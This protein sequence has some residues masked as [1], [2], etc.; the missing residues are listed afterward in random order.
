MRTDGSDPAPTEMHRRAAEGVTGPGQRL[1]HYPQIQRAFGRH[2]LS[3]VRA[4]VDG[5]A[6]VASRGINAQAYALGERVAF[7]RPPTLHTAAHEAAHVIQQRRGV[8]LPMGIGQA[9]DRY[10]RH[11]NQVADRVVAGQ[12]AADLLDPAPAASGRPASLQR[13]D[14]QY[15]YRENDTETVIK[16]PDAQGTLQERARAKECDGTAAIVPENPKKGTSPTPKAK[17]ISQAATRAFGEGFIAGHLLNMQLGGTGR[18]MNITAFT[19]TDNG[20]HERQIEAHMKLAAGLTVRKQTAANS[21]AILVVNAIAERAI[22]EKS[23]GGQ[24]RAGQPAAVGENL[25]HSL[26][27][28]HATIDEN[29]GKISDWIDYSPL[30]LGPANST[31][32]Q[33]FGTGGVFDSLKTE[34]R[35]AAEKI[36]PGQQGGGQ[37]AG[38]ANAGGN[39]V[40]GN[41]SF[42]PRVSFT[43]P[44]PDRFGKISVNKPQ[45]TH[46]GVVIENADLKLKH[47][48]KRGL[49]FKGGTMA[50]ALAMG[51]MANAK[52][53]QKVSLEPT[54]DP[55]QANAFDAKATGNEFPGLKSGL[56]Q[57]LSERV[58]T[59]GRLV[60]G[61]VEA[62]LQVSKGAL[63]NSGLILQKSTLKGRLDQSGPSLQGSIGI[64]DKGE[65]IK[66]QLDLGWSGEGVT[67]KGAATVKDVIDGLAPFTAAVSYQNG[68]NSPDGL[69]LSVD[70]VAYQKTV[71][72]VG[73]SGQAKNLKYDFKTGQFSGQADL[74]ADINPL[75]KVQAQAKIAENR[76]QQAKLA[77]QSPAVSFPKEKPIFAGSLHSNL[78]YKDDAITGRIGGT[79]DLQIPGLQNLGQ[80]KPIRLTLDAGIADTGAV[81]ANLALV[82][83]VQFSPFFKLDKL[84]ASID[85]N[86]KISFAGGMTLDSGLFSPAQ[87]TLSYA[88]GKLSGAGT[89]GIPKGKIIG[90]D[91][92]S[93]ELSLSDDG[94]AG[95]GTLKPSLKQIKEGRVQ[96]AY[97]R[98]QGLSFGGGLT[99]G[100]IPYIKGGAVDFAVSKRPGAQQYDV[101][102]AGN[103]TIAIAG[104]TANG[105]A[106]YDNGAFTIE[107]RAYYK[108][109]MA[110]GMVSVGVTN[111]VVDQHGKIGTQIGDSLS[112]FGKGA[113]AV[114]LTSWLK[115]TAGIKLLPNGELIID[116]GLALARPVTLFKRRGYNKKLFSVGMDI[117][118]LGFVVPVIRQR[119]GIFA[120]IGGSMTLG[121]GIGPGTI[122]NAKL[123]ITYNPSRPQDT[124]LSG[125]ARLRIPANAGVKLSIHGALGAGIPIISAT[126]GLEASGKLGVS[127]ALDT[128]I[129]LAWNPSQGL[130]FEAFGKISAQPKLRFDL[131]GFAK[132]EADVYLT[133]YELYRKN[134]RLASIEFGPNMRLGMKFPVKYDKKRGLQLSW[135]N[136]TFEKPK[137][138]TRSLLKG[139][140]GKAK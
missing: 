118:I 96:A 91:G 70:Q 15:F 6:A 95:S 1:P 62:T 18:P 28:A 113:V 5:P 76:L 126:L 93:I 106:S 19:R 79:A 109:G 11:A 39:S 140:V 66:G 115:G 133:T 37:N 138:D 137:V 105:K 131:T 9:G 29:S 40:Q 44:R 35:A 3:G 16:T 111:R 2:D 75:G 22:F 56:D 114:K 90:V 23:A 64:S 77:Y 81:S 32:S 34:V 43:F 45:V 129:D 31:A 107:G 136:V 14:A 108:R 71:S 7:A 58:K 116:G 89:I 73:L 87:L 88:N 100:D 97:S 74:A 117:P 99:L 41:A 30:S 48:R 135:R 103:F 83:A 112:P 67:V 36:L 85:E 52:K 26:M 55:R 121:A 33:T 82:E 120:N 132:V 127:G 65:K 21:S 125:S 61:G 50:V 134:W 53:P 12:S 4:Y 49:K 98:K 63:G 84:Q 80:N 68:S 86:K 119:V 25:A 102:A 47:H 57:F 51:D 94:I 8:T 101:R 130:S 139:L 54:D 24:A 59:T 46:P 124:K 17:K 122:R 78:F 92:A 104:L 72:G 20:H 42:N 69:R 13:L 27:G 123:H 128:G 38:S 110:E 10:E 60:D